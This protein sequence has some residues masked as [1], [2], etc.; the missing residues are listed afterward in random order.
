MPTYDTI[1]PIHAIVE[2]GSGEAG[3]EAGPGEQTSVEV[4]PADTSR[5]ADVALAEQTEITYADGTLTVRSPREAARGWSSKQPPSVIVTIRLPAE[6]K[7]TAD[8]YFGSVRATGSFGDVEARTSHGDISLEETAGVRAHSEHGAITITRPIGV[9]EIATN[10]NVRIGEAGSTVRIE[11]GSGDIDIDRVQADLN[12][13]SAHGNIRIARLVSGTA[14]L[15]TGYGAVSVGVARTTAA[16]VDVN[17]GHGA[18]RDSLE[19]GR[20]PI[21][22]DAKAAIHART[23]YGDIDVHRA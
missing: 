17:S 8:A 4:R 15:E 23:T 2:F 18:V 9:A 3:I 20:A 19:T 10:G 22:T 13:T 11:A 12:A 7:L 6:S 21:H 5:P 14:V 16:D 1:G